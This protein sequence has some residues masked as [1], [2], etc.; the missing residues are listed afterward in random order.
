[1]TSGN[2]QEPVIVDELQD[3]E[4]VLK[5]CVEQ[6]ESVEATRATLI[7]QLKE[8]LHDQVW[9]HFLLCHKL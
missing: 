1:M 8:A 6:L 7:S 3:Q 5:Q 2:Q 9:F 4:N